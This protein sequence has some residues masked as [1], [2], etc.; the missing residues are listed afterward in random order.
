MKCLNGKRAVGNQDGDYMLVYDSN[1]AQYYR[2]ERWSPKVIVSGH[3][4][5]MVYDRQR[6]ASACSKSGGRFCKKGCVLTRKIN[7]TDD[8]RSSWQQACLDSGAESID[9][10]SYTQ[11][12]VEPASGCN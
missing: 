10:C 5:A 2:A 1:P 9:F 11:Q 3:T 4:V 7:A 8:M 6:T 12:E